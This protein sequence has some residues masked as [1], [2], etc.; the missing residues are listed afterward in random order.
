MIF[1]DNWGF[2]VD[3]TGDGGDSA[4]A[5][6]ILKL[7][8]GH[9][10]DLGKVLNYARGAGE[11]VRHPT[12]VP[13]N[14]PKNFTRDQLM[15]LAPAMSVTSFAKRI[16]LATLK[17]GGF[18]QNFERDWPGTTK[19]PW[20][21]KVDGKWRLFDFA[22]PIMPHH[23]G[24]LAACAGY[25]KLSMLG[26]PLLALSCIFNSTS[27]DNEQN[28]LQCMIKIVGP[29]AIKLYKKYN[30]NWVIQTK[31]YWDRRNQSE[32]ADA[33]INNL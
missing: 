6:G 26:W 33:I 10:P 22:D 31:Y 25:R 14:N 32:I 2:P 7:F 13:W 23:L 1:L 8:A 16:L 5:M 24:H 3:E 11:L 15:C 4:R 21:H 12:Q 17:R 18:A 27:I 28:Q 19:Y 20:P 30:T 9:T 29:W